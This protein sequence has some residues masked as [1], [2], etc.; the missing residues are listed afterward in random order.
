MIRP[1]KEITDPVCNFILDLFKIRYVPF[2]AAKAAE[3]AKLL[4]LPKQP[5]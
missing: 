5:F 4:E 2:I 1:L 3:I